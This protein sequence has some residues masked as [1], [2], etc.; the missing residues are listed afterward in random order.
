MELFV[1]LKQSVVCRGTHR[2]R[3]FFYWEMNEIR[4]DKGFR[5][6]R[7][8]LKIPA[9]RIDVWIFLIQFMFTYMYC[10]AF[11]LN[12]PDLWPVLLSDTNQNNHGMS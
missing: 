8:N 12:M 6:G 10:P 11:A 9:E 4:F 2:L 3:D 5:V 1:A 7:I